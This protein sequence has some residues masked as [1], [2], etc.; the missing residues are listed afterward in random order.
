MSPT[1]FTTGL[2]STVT[3]SVTDK[4]TVATYDFYIKASWGGS[5]FQMMDVAGNKLFKINVV[6][7]PTSTS[8]GQGGFASSFTSVQYIP[9]DGTSFFVLP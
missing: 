6:C 9:G 8:I 7:G 1:S 3:V 5:A 2:T 4:P